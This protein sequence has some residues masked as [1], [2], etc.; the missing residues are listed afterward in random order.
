VNVSVAPRLRQACVAV[1]ALVTIHR[2]KEREAFEQKLAKETKLQ[3]ID[4]IESLC[5][6]CDLLCGSNSDLHASGR[7]IPVKKIHR[8]RKARRRCT[9][10]ASA[11]EEK[12]S[13]F[14]SFVNFCLNFPSLPSV[15]YS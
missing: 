14:V 12:F 1:M 9:L 8:G 15:K 2:R 5:D 10:A 3:K 13:Y 11:S 6:L 4:V 7:A